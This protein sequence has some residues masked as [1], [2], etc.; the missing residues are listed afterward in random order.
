MG[1][2][3]DAK[4]KRAAPMAPDERRRAIIDAV[5][6]LLTQHG[7]DVTTKQIAEAAGIAEGTIFR[8]FPDKQALLWAT[9]EDTI[10]S[11][12]G[13][14]HMA[15]TMA[16]IPELR[17]KVIAT[18]EQIVARTEKVFAVM[19]ALRSALIADGAS[20]TVKPPVGPPPFIIDANEA[21]VK[22]L[23]DLVFKPHRDEMRIP[24]V[25]AAVL[26]R[27]V[28]FGATHPGM[29]HT[30]KPLSPAD[31]ADALLNGVTTSSQ[32]DPG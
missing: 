27:S 23:T 8:V 3:Q 18:I 32:R 17:G 12:G 20:A 6:P 9:A 19:M 28:V 11:A 25:K 7:P 26:L 31:I 30:A 1:T 13:R 4:R 14:E 15:A 24:P 22:N 16:G 21:L 5:V 10:N 29:W 2:G